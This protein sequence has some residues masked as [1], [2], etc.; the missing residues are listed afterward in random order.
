VETGEGAATSVAGKQD[1]G[2][3]TTTTATTTV[4]S[5]L[6]RA[7]HARAGLGF[8]HTSSRILAWYRR[9]CKYVLTITVTLSNF[10]IH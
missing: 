4:A 10:S 3:A 5:S 2:R 1:G 8:E 7:M 9:Y 6:M